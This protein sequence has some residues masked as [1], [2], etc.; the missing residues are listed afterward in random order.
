MPD[1]VKPE[2][3]RFM[4]KCPIF[5]IFR[6]EHTLKTFQLIYCESRFEDCARFKLAS[7][8]T[9]PGPRLLPDGTILSD[10]IALPE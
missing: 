9:M 1:P 7:T 10:R 4:A 2:Q 6:C 8:G 3:C 5:P